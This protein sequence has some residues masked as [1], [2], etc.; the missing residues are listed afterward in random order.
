M[1]ENDQRPSGGKPSS[2]SDPAVMQTAD[3]STTLYLPGLDETYHSRHG[4]VQESLHVFVEMG[5]GFFPS[6]NLSILEVGFGTGLNSLLTLCKSETRDSSV[7]Y[8]SLETA[9]LSLEV[10][11]QLSFPGYG[12]AELLMALHDAAWN[13][14]VEMTRNFT[15]QKVNLGIQEFPI[16]EERFDLIYYDAFGP[17]AQP[18]MWTLDIFHRLYKTLRTGGILV[19]YCSKGQVRRDMQQAGFRVEKLPGP[20]GKRE[21]VRALK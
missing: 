1:P 16:G 17:R 18:E 13:E 12:S 9:P 4:A 3:G 7:H 6:G 21:M 11:R 8:V 14:P 19:T 2:V 20:P 5:M 10:V 15:L